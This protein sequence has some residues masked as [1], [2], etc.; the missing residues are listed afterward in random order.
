MIHAIRA[1]VMAEYGSDLTDPSRVR[2]FDRALGAS[3]RIDSPA[4]YVAVARRLATRNESNLAFGGGVDGRL[5]AVGWNHMTPTDMVGERGRSWL[6]YWQRAASRPEKVGS[7]YNPT[8]EVAFAGWLQ[9]VPARTVRLHL[10]AGGRVGDRV[11][12]ARITRAAARS[13]VPE[14][15]VVGHSSRGWVRRIT[16][17][18]LDALGRLSPELQRAALTVSGYYDRA[19]WPADGAAGRPFGARDIRWDLVGRVHRDMVADTSGRVRHAWRAGRALAEPIKGPGWG[20]WEVRRAELQR[21]ADSAGCDWSTRSKLDHQ[22]SAHMAT[23]PEIELCP[24]YPQAPREI[25]ARIVRGETPVEIAASVGVEFSRAEA[26]A[27]LLAGGGDHPV[28]WLQD[29][30]HATDA[31]P[32]LPPL[33]DP[34]VIRWLAEVRRRG[35]W[36]QLTRERTVHGPGG[37]VAQ[38]CFLD[39]L[40]EVA[41]QDLVRGVHTRVE[42]AFRAVAQ[43]YG[44]AA[45]NA[46][47]HD[48]RVLAPA[49]RWRVFPRSQRWLVTPASLVAE[50]SALGHCVGGYSSAVERGQSAILSQ[51]IGLLRST[52]E[53]DPRSGRVLQHYGPNNSQPAPVLVRLFNRFLAR[54]GLGGVECR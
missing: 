40:D 24:A 16:D 26:H 30:L 51:Q 37:E 4:H 18:A 43:R 33:R 25:G 31:L 52:V 36:A 45:M 38:F 8:P 2:Q 41:E 7:S 15:A 19:Q 21:A 11:R 44:E 22:V 14:G 28:G 39:R 3:G 9:H 13:S 54:N 12:L 50:G 42:D 10:W 53:I 29:H 5:L 23:R 17:G 49:P 48:F 20:A 34:A 32:L 47:R 1:I 27:W 46:H 6:A 35:S